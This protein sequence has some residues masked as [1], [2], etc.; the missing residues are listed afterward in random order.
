MDL[1][2]VKELSSNFREHQR[3]CEADRDDISD[4]K[5]R[6][7]RAIIEA[8]C[9]IIIHWDGCLEGRVVAPREG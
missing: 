7:E 9:G 2:R 5:A 3:D 8:Q 1:D 6:I 4:V